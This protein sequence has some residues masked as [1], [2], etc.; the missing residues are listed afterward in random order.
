[1][2]GEGGTRFV[3]IYYV[4]DCGHIFADSVKTHELILLRYQKGGKVRIEINKYNK[5]NLQREF[6]SCLTVFFFLYILSF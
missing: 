5:Y 6:F 4:H 2:R 3:S 1:M